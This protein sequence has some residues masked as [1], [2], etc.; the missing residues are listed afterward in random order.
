VV[1]A[2]GTGTK[3]GINEIT[4]LPKGDPGGVRPVIIEDS[5]I[6]R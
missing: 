5:K 3:G 2:P 1:V 6:S 4:G